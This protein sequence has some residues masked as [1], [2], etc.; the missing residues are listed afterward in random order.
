MP[1]TRTIQ[2]NFT[3]GFVDE[4]LIGRLDLEQYRSGCRQAENVLTLPQGPIRRR[5]GTIF[6]DTLPGVFAQNATVP[7]MP[8]GGTA[9]VI[10]DDDSTTSTVTTA[11][12]STTNPYVVAH[13]DLGAAVDALFVD[14]TGIGFDAT[15]TN[16]EFALQWSADDSAWTTLKVLAGITEVA[17]DFRVSGVSARYWRVARI[18]ATDLGTL[19]I[20]I[21][22]FLVWV[23]STVSNVRMSDF[24][25]TDDDKYLLVYTYR[26]LRIYK[27]DVILAN[28]GTR[29]L[30][31]E[32]SGIEFAQADTAMVV[33]M[34]DHAP[35]RLIKGT[36]DADWV[37]TDIPF[38]NV[39]QLD[40]NDASSPAPTSYICQLT[41]TNFTEGDRFQIDIGTALTT[42]IS[43]TTVTATLFENI[44]KEVQK[45]YLLGETGASVAGSATV[46]TITLAG[47]SAGA[48]EAPVAFPVSSANT[49]AAIAGIRTQVGVS[50]REDVWSAGRGYPRTVAFYQSRMYFWGT[51]SKAQSLMGSRVGQFFDFDTGEGF[52]D[53]AIFITLNTRSRNSASA[54][55]P[56]RLLQIFS[57]SAEFAV[58][59]VPPTPGNITPQSQTNHGT[60]SVNPVEI[61]GSTLFIE[62][63]GRTL[64]EFLFSLQEQAFLG[65]SLS[66]LAQSLINVPVDMVALR[67]RSN[68]DSNYV[69]IINTD[70]TMAVY[71]VLRSQGIGAFTKWTTSG[72]IIS[73]RSVDDMLYLTTARNSKNFLEKQS[74]DVYTDSAVSKT[75]SSS[76]TI[77]GLDHLEGLEVRVKADGAVMLS[78]TVV[79]GAITTERAATVVEVGLNYIPIIQPMPLTPDTQVGSSQM[80]IKKIIETRLNV[81]DTQGLIV[82]ING[83]EEVRLPDRAFAESS[84]SPLNTVPAPYTGIIPFIGESL[85]YADERLQSVVITQRDP[86]PMTIASIFTKV[87]TS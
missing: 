52:D 73:G 4:Q 38:T 69:F 14:V 23:E 71:N 57:T 85:G 16:G 21:S 10:I 66:F 48:Y 42:T 78:Q 50:R 61:D 18:G 5:P 40:Y 37:F 67:G 11:G 68:D 39:T 75:Q 24:E 81:I 87:E 15:G 22:G 25:L 27:D 32:I 59:Q 33:V 80:D 26:N 7:T 3:T 84:T 28:L 8:N 86:L 51:K 54:I 62:R 43:Y 17:Q 47:S 74:D 30:D 55:V 83:I 79:G 12:I 6:I 72:N 53:E 1:K 13:Y 29:Y 36:T 49:A 46:V 41:F 34:E 70:G 19:H 45:L 64:R 65:S 82:S 63:K 60:S 20:D 9:S 35:R 44:R 56:A 76:A 2:S 31:A 77:T 58:A